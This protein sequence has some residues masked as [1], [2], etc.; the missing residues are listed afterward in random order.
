MKEKL[1]RAEFIEMFEL[2]WSESCLHESSY[3]ESV[4]AETALQEEW[5]SM[6]DGLEEDYSFKRWK[7]TAAEKK[8]YMKRAE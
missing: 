8:K 7:L 3:I 6:Q 5:D 4:G 1:T 2:A